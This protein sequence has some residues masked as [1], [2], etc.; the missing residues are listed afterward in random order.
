MS[1]DTQQDVFLRDLILLIISK[2]RVV[3]GV[4]NL[5]VSLNKKCF[6]SYGYSF[7]REEVKKEIFQML[8]ID[9]I[10]MIHGP[11]KIGN[12]SQNVLNI[13]ITD[14]GMRSL[15]RNSFFEEIAKSF[16]L[17]EELKEK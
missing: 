9:L 2:D 15:R 17:K 12:S 6:T 11:L 4:S 16:P 13:K 14:S 5:L 10:S 8:Q 1:V 7:D 3:E